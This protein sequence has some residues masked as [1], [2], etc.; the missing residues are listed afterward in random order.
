M[1]IAYISLHWPR[2]KT[3]SIGKKILLQSQTWQN[4]GHEVRFFSHLHTVDDEENLINGERFFYKVEN[5]TGGFLKTEFNRIAAAKKLIKSVNNYNPDLIYLRWSMF[6]FPVHRLAKIAP[7]VLEI[8][9]NDLMEH[10]LL[11]FLMDRY[12]RCTRRFTIGSAKGLVFATREL[13]KNNSFTKFKKPSAVIPN[14][15]EME[16]T[17]S[18]PAPSNQ[19]PHLVFIGTPGMAWQGVDKLVDFAD[20]FKDIHIDLVGFKFIEGVDSIPKNISMH[21]F[22]RGSHFEDILSKADAA[23]GTMALHRKGMDEASSLKTRDVLARGIPCILPYKDTA[24]SGLNLNEILQIPNTPD[25]IKIHGQ[26]IHDF[27]FSMRGKRI[28]RD[29]LKGKISID[30]LESLRLDFFQKIQGENPIQ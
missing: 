21:G 2:F 15:I 10:K 19:K 28:S 20:R 25:N 18:Y 5:R 4:H 7:I 24:V 8:N 3:S 23:I 12:N 22:L 11:G 14:G 29:S 6:V 17:S 1:K 30:V 27:I 26:K 13:S 9:T 16:R